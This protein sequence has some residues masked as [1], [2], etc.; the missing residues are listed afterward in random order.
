MTQLVLVRHGETVWH[1][2]NRYAGSSD[3]ALTAHG[4]EQAAALACWAKS[5]GLAKIYV[6]PL[7]RAR[8]TAGAAAYGL[9]LQPQVDLRLRELD[10]GQGE[11]LT[12]GELKAK[13]PAQYA[14]FVRDP[15]ANPLPGGEDPRDALRRVHAAMADMVREVPEGR[16]LAVAHSTLIRLL[17]CDLLGIDPARYRDVFPKVNN[18]ALTELRLLHD[19]PAALL[20][21]N[22]PLSVEVPDIQEETPHAR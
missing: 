22:L 11:G 7:A 17:L 16:V 9:H 2:E 19:K 1:A 6:S 10:F 14:A 4:E 18:V 8:A 21:F 12:P 3:I 13:F 15:V 20:S 5:A